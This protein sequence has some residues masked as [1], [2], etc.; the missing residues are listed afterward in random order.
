MAKIELVPG[1]STEEVGKILGKHPNRI[2]EM[3]NAGVIDALVVV[4]RIFI[5]QSSLDAYIQRCAKAGA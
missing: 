5:P 1:L 4:D 3:V 2:R